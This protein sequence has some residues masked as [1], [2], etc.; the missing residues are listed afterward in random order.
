MKI[1]ILF[2]LL[3]VILYYSLTNMEN[4]Q[5]PLPGSYGW[6]YYYS[7]RFG[8]ARDKCHYHNDTIHCRGVVDNI[9]YLS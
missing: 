8:N 3:L 9:I 2:L 7:L 1:V 5:R 4:F 6:P